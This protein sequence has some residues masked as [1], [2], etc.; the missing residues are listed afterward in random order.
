MIIEEKEFKSIHIDFKQKGDVIFGKKDGFFYQK[1]LNDPP[2]K[3]LDGPIK[4]KKIKNYKGYTIKYNLNGVYG[5]S[6]WK[7]EVC[8]EDNFWEI[9]E[10]E[11]CI[12]NIKEYE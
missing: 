12:K 10:A 7:E 9:K 3:V 6:V 1:I 2:L 8:L 4:Y 11:E 5:F